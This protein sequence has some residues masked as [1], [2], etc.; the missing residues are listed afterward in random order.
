MLQ[1]VFRW[2]VVDCGKCS[3]CG[4]RGRLSLA[5]ITP[6]AMTGVPERWWVGEAFGCAQ[7]RYG[8]VSQAAFIF[9]ET[10]VGAGNPCQDCLV[11]ENDG[12]WKRT[13]AIFVFAP[14]MCMG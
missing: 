6:G 10:S 5:D 11:F 14:E 3:V 13:A 8:A 2:F 1:A 9:S 7:L 4:T 12:F